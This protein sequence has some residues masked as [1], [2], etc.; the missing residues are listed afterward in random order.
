MVDLVVAALDGDKAE[1]ITVID[2]RGRTSIADHMVIAAGHSARQVGA[3]ADHLI[4]TMKA[5]GIRTSVE[6]LPQ[7]DWVLVDGGDI[8]VH[9]FR[10]EVRSF[11]N[12]EK[13]WG[14][15]AVAG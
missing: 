15:E 2:L 6:G 7:C 10:P 1:D 12:L 4:E 8:I 14:V 13:M 9:L 5:A 11:Y 3:M